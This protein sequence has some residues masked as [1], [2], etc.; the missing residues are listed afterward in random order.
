MLL[1]PDPIP[2]HF[3]AASFS[4]PK[5]FSGPVKAASIPTSLYLKLDASEMEKASEYAKDDV[6]IV[7]TNAAMPQSNSSSETKGASS[8]SKKRQWSEE[9]EGEPLTRA[10]LFR[11]VYHGPSSK[12][13]IEL[14]PAVPYER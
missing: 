7:C 4:S 9:D 11:A 13:M 6:W 3:P 5:G 14:T 10:H 2:Q 8:G 12:S 1:P